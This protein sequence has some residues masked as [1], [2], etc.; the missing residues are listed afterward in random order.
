[1]TI[2]LHV[3]L[4][5]HWYRRQSL[6]RLFVVFVLSSFSLC[7]GQAGENPSQL[8]D[9]PTRSI[10]ETKR[11]FARWAD[12]YR[13]DWHGTAASGPAPQR[14]GPPSPLDSPPFPN[15]DWSY[16]GSPV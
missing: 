2:T 3:T 12:F 14:R 7:R 9:A 10:S 13:Q 5:D 6:F 4:P 11:F 15:S 16:G 1:M 8:P